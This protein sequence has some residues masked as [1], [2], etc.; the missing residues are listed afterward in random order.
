MTEGEGRKMDH[1]LRFTDYASRNTFLRLLRLASA[2]KWWMALAVLLGSLT[3][4]SS[5]GLMAT[6]AYIIASAALHPSIADLAVP[7]VGVRFF[8]IARG[9]FR[10]LERYISHYVN[11][12]LLARLRVW[13]YS[14]VEPLAPA[15]LMHYRSGDLLT[16][17]VGDIETLQNF[18][19]R[20]IAPPMIA[21][22][23]AVVMGA[24]LS[25]FSPA[26]ALVVLAFMFAV[27][28][29][30]PVGVQHISQPTNRQTV[31]LRAELNTQL[32]DGIQGIADLLA[33]GGEQAHAVRVKTLS[34]ELVRLQGRMASLTG[35][36]NAAGNL[37]T[38]LAMWTVLV[39]AIPMVA[40]ARLDGVYLPVIA[41]AVLASFEGVLALPLAFQYLESNLQSARRLFEIVDVPKVD[42]RRP[43]ATDRREIAAVSGRRSAVVVEDLT[44][45]YAPDEPLALEHVSFDLREGESLAL[46]GPSG[47]G[48]TTLVNLLLRFW[49][50][51]E[52]RI[53]VGGRDLREYDPDA[54]RRLFGVVSQPTHLFNASIRENLMLARPQAIEAE[55]IHAAQQAQMHDFIR[56]LP[57]GYD[58]L[59][60]EQGL[61]LSGGERQRL[62]IARALLAARD[63]PIILLDEPT[64]NLDPVTEHQVLRAIRGLTDVTRRATL[65][66]THR[67]VGLEGMGEIVV[68]CA[69]RVAEHGRHSEL[70]RLN[71]L[72]RRMWEL[73]NQILQAEG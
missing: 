48:K 47:A 64:A 9:V 13:F 15:R 36:H 56:A 1:I 11:F 37:L 67:L 39:I 19:V 31:Q 57:Q 14:A 71:G 70:L 28:V 16:R 30:V 3:I 40:S 54:A 17:I 35:L 49:D 8:G 7:I 33:F 44:F 25:E 20:I 43:Q 4:G 41:L 38:H 65:I 45:R 50:Y 22:T 46:V 52:G 2:F 66:I 72:Y 51:A 59:I 69:G 60:G 27:G 68:L 5:I 53:V 32:V 73:Q 34:R 6:S 10:Y 23:I 55:M 21:L 62:A 18:Y 26:L 61:R 42:N 24:F 63:A 12:S 58:T 29:V